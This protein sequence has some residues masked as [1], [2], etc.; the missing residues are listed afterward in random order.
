[1]RLEDYLEAHSE[2]PSHFAKRISRVP[3]TI[4][5]ILPGKNGAPKRRPSLA[6]IEQIAKATGGAVTANDFVT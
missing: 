6:L 3:S 5:R 2:R 4:S 1:M